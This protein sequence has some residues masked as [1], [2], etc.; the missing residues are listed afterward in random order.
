MTAR[1]T[2]RTVL[3][4][5][6]LSGAVFIVTSS[7]GQTALAQAPAPKRTELVQQKVDVYRLWAERAPGAQGDLDDETPTLTVFRPQGERANGTA[8]VIAPGGAYIGLA[9][10]LE[11]I[12]PAAWFTTRGVT[13]FIL[14][15]RVGPKA[16]LPIPLLDGARAIR[17][18]RAN[19][20]AFNVDPERIGMM[21]FSAGGHLAATTA[22]D[23]TAGEPDARDPIERV[24]SRPD[25]LILA[26]PWLE[27][28]Q[29]RA[30]GTS[31]YCDFAKMRGGPTCDPR[32]YAQF[33]PV[34]H[35]TKAAPPTFLFHTTDDEL[36]PVAGTVRFYE[37]LVSSGVPAELHAF[38]TGSHGSGLGGRSPAL[39]HWP[40]LLEEWLRSR[41]LLPESATGPARE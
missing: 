26:Y 1:R 30:D 22:V 7:F 21:G 17:F 36:V 39:S 32:E 34:E 2:S 38:E 27:G 19:A 9:G 11:G 28:M 41:R 18:V 40:E 24:S 6:A 25:F 5:A 3:A 23:A 12:E 35:V 14:E 16:R 29:V 15:Y 37:A 10:M 33:R 13:A 31:S 4:Q 8:V 20:D